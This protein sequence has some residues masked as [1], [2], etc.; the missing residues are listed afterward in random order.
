MP[1]TPAAVSSTLQIPSAPAL[2][3]LSSKAFEKGSGAVDYAVPILDTA[4][5]IQL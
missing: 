2:G 4:E 3:G 1:I 5:D